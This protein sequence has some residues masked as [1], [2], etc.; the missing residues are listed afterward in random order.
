VTLVETLLDF[1]LAFFFLLKLFYREKKKRF[2]MG[3][4]KKY[5]KQKHTGKF[6]LSGIHNSKSPPPSKPTNKPISLLN[7][8]DE[9]IVYSS[10]YVF[11]IEVAILLINSK[12][13]RRH[14]KNTNPPRP[15][16]AFMLYR[17]DKTA[18]KKLDPECA[19][20]KQCEISKLIAEEWGE[21]TPEVKEL[22]RA[23]ARLSEKLHLKT[24][25]E[26]KYVPKKQTSNKQKKEESDLS[27]S[28]VSTDLSSF[29][30]GSPISDTGSEVGSSVSEMNNI[31]SDLSSLDIGSPISDNDDFDIVRSSDNSNTNYV[32]LALASNDNL[33]L[34]ISSFNPT[35]DNIIP[36]LDTGDTSNMALNFNI[37]DS[38][39][40]HNT[41]NLALDISNFGVNQS[42]D[43]SDTRNVAWNSTNGSAPLP[44]LDPQF[45]SFAYNLYAMLQTSPNCFTNETAS[46]ILVGA[47]ENTVAPPEFSEP[48]FSEQ[49][50]IIQSDFNNNFENDF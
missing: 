39:N 40:D 36:S 7:K 47:P 14:K 28:E 35:L 24:H 21:E 27:N 48:G 8:T 9:E 13:T 6:Y 18:N 45:I 17:R 20:L 32:S 49:D 46:E 34:D 29:E 1:C 16:N 50:Y 26:Y 5:S 11:T 42:Y 19:G 37:N 31:T 2:E 23:L 12:T 44:P 43:N 41:N 15:Q 38:T 25:G 3:R 30:V 4:T 10:N 33:P 22:F